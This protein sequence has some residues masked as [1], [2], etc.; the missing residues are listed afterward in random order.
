MPDNKRMQWGFPR[1]IVKWAQEDGIPLS[2]YG[3]R[4]LLRQGKI[5]VRKIGAKNLICYKN[6]LDYLDC[7]TGCDN[8][9]AELALGSG[10][11]RIGA[12]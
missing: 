7:S 10:I 9:P 12:G 8:A 5:P 11:R 1:T 2:E 4:L 3:L 6:V